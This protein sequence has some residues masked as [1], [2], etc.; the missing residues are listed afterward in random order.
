MTTTLQK[1]Q[2]LFKK[3][4]NNYFSGWPPTGS[5][6]VVQEFKINPNTSEFRLSYNTSVDKVFNPEGDA[7]FYYPEAIVLWYTLG[8]ATTNLLKNRDIPQE[9]ININDEAKTFVQN[10]IDKL[11]DDTGKFDININVDMSGKD[12]ARAFNIVD[13]SVEKGVIQENEFD[14]KWNYHWDDANWGG[15]TGAGLAAKIEF[16]QLF[17]QSTF[18][19]NLK[20]NA[21]TLYSSEFTAA[22]Y[23]KINFK[24]QAKGISE[25]NGSVIPGSSF[26][27]SRYINIIFFDDYFQKVNMQDD[28]A[29]SE[30][31]SEVAKSGVFGEDPEKVADTLKKRDAKESG[32]RADL[33]K[34]AEEEE[35]RERDAFF[36]KI[37]Q[38]ILLQGLEKIAAHSVQ[39]RKS[40][41]NGGPM[42]S[43][44]TNPYKVPYG[45]RVYCLNEK[46]NLYMNLANSDGLTNFYT[47]HLSPE[48]SE[49]L[50]YSFLISKVNTVKIDE[51]E[52]DIEMPLLFEGA[53]YNGVTPV[54]DHTKLF[55]GKK[56]FKAIQNQ[57][58]T[59]E[60]ISVD[61]WMANSAIKFD[62]VSIKFHGENQA[63]AK[64][65]V[66]VELKISV[67]NILTLQTIFKAKTQILKDTES[68]E[69]EYEYG[70]IDLITYLHR[71][72][73]GDVFANL[74]KNGARYYNPIYFK[75]YGRLVMKIFP[76]M[77][78]PQYHQFSQFKEKEYYEK[79]YNH[80]NNTPLILDLAHVDHTIQKEEET[81]ATTISI[82]YKGYVRSFLQDP[83]FDILRSPQQKKTA[84][85]NE[86][87]FITKL[88]DI[89]SQKE[90][91]QKIDIY[92]TEQQDQVSRLATNCKLIKQLYNNSRIY[93]LSINSRSFES[94][95]SDTYELTSDNT[96]YNDISSYNIKVYNSSEEDLIADSIS[97]S[98]S[99]DGGYNINYFY[100]G[101]LIERAMSVMYTS[102]SAKTLPDILKPSMDDWNLSVIMPCF[103]PLKT[104]DKTRVEGQ[105]CSLA[106]FPISVEHFARWWKEEVIDAK[107]YF[108]TIGTLINRVIND[109]IN[110]SLQEACYLNGSFTRTRFAMSS[111]FGMYTDANDPIE[112]MKKLENNLD[113]FHNKISLKFG[114]D[115]TSFIDNLEGPYFKKNPNILRQHHKNYIFIYPIQSTFNMYENIDNSLEAWEER[116]IPN[117]TQNMIIEGID[118]ESQFTKTLSF[119]KDDANYRAESRFQAENLYTLAQLASV[120]N[121][122]SKTFPALDIFPGMLIWVNAGFWQQ[123]YA[124]N[125]IP[126]ILGLGG[127]HLV[128]SVTHHASIDGS[129]LSEFTT[130]I[131]ANWVSNGSIKR[132]G[133]TPSEDEKIIQLGIKSD[134]IVQIL[135][136]GSQVAA[137][138]FNSRGEKV[139]LILK[140]E[141]SDQIQDGTTA[142]FEVSYANDYYKFEE[143][144]YY[145]V[146]P[147]RDDIF[148]ILVDDVGTGRSIEVRENERFFYI[149]IDDFDV[150]L[151]EET[152][153]QKYRKSITIT[154]IK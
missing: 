13:S 9:D 108:Y 96:I 110:P 24:F 66:D 153:S 25:I 48:I 44:G 105:V 21:K 100:F 5:A 150:S 123:P 23:E 75:N 58:T 31:L 60:L 29:I 81:Q 135:D 84:I 148:E 33:S 74:T 8:Y 88:K 41:V 147:K 69:Y 99:S 102:A 43:E 6:G 92:N 61:P 97:G 7:V 50:N 109:I 56:D 114:E 122:T 131:T 59:A 132:D 14:K 117:L 119:S 93:S 30:K 80:L 154:I 87:K 51:K 65:N 46:D 64:T 34:K 35:K 128:E 79:I 85:E 37:E 32:V 145:K 77:I 136:D 151:S 101:D 15:L 28:K 54:Y 127:Y 104:V 10:Y 91:L 22:S 26:T 3:Y 42:G 83:K 107:P 94:S 16:F 45:G 141:S 89:T 130:T 1:N 11:N 12:I 143:E 146:F 67:P 27:V 20:G 47:S 139:D 86:K 116:N 17:L 63:T 106:D 144:H 4:V 129:D 149:L 82:T 40:Y 120:Y 36:K 39:Q 18:A 71:S 72:D 134:K 152:K 112:N 2:N 49:L 111:E 133:K 78:E 125:S 103:K 52:Y 90:A 98:V 70:L 138:G 68:E 113:R 118:G 121:V 142:S 55:A 124:E 115:K 19:R 76:D 137:Q 140:R 73:L 53:D 62:D 57:L 126:N 38:C 95:V